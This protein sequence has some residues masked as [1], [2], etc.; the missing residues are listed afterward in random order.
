MTEKRNVLFVDDE[1]RVLRGLRR[2]LRSHASKW[3]MQFVE[4]GAEA[5]EEL[6]RQHY[7]V[8]VSDMKM[9]KMDGIGLL[10]QVQDKHPNVVRIVLSGY[11]EMESAMRAVPV[12]HQFLTKLCAPDRLEEVIERALSL[13]HL[14]SDE[15]LRKTVGRMRNLP[16]LPHV[17]AELTSKLADPETS[18]AQLS[19]IVEKD[20]GI[21]ANVLRVVNSAFFGLPQ[22]VTRVDRAVA[23]L[24]ITMLKDLA[25]AIEVFRVFEGADAK[26]FS[27]ITEQQHVLNV[28]R[29]ASRLVE[30]KHQSDDAFLAGMLHDVG[31]LILASK[32]PKRLRKIHEV[33][34]AKELPPHK[35]E[36]A[37]FGVSHSEL[38]AYLLGMW[39]LPY[40]IVEAVAH[41]HDPMRVEQKSFDVL[42]AVYVA[43]A[44]VDEA[45]NRP[46]REPLNMEYLEKMG[47]LDREKDW[48][49]IADEVLGN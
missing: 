31:R 23:F 5:L 46:F 16:S 22:T 43:N 36:M 34:K 30:G 1:P 6:D 48:R 38:G 12:A 3:D 10:Q 21:C 19:K 45:A 14:L 25:L 4:S 2:M 42:G 8:I 37:L 24:G 17:Y 11:P 35:A 26:L 27:P 9:V 33:M 29:L 41:H 7:D 44:L 15:S 20:A 47:V 18:L 40:H 32:L 28:S 49:A 39:G 13:T